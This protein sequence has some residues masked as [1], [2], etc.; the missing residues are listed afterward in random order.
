[1]LFEGLQLPLTTP[2][3]A[4][5][6]LNLPKLE[7]NVARYSRTPVAGLV[8]LSETGE[9]TMLSDE[10]RRQTLRS[11]AEAA[12]IEKVLLAGVSRD[13]VAGTLDLAEFAAGAGYDAVLVKTPS[14]FRANVR[15]EAAKGLVN[16]FR[17]VADRSALPVVLYSSNPEPADGLAV[18]V[19][20]ELASHPQIIG[21]IDCAGARGRF[22]KISSGT[23]GVEREVSVTAVFAAVT[24]RMRT[25][26][27]AVAG[28]LIASDALAG[29]GGAVVAVA[30]ARP[31]A[32]TRMKK[33]GFQLLA[34]STARMFEGLRAGAV[35]AMAAFAASAPQACYEVLAAWKD[36]DEGLAE[37]KQSRLERIAE[38]VEEQLG[39][40]GIKFGCDLNGYFG[41]RPRSPLLPLT[42]EERA[43]IETLMRGL[44]N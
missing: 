43:E 12:S 39:V 29:G 28:E 7:S 34:G 2:F 22:E 37:E 15:G 33:V 31:A 25:R 11:I 23:S 30:A 24:G 1:M 13:S 27:E 3:Y 9:P 6:R 20:A 26:N 5:G 21:L 14:L 16:Y 42:G 44:R 36:G 32:R 17:A 10:E 8:A 40:A 4:D 35:G 18:E 41:G 38:R 19:V